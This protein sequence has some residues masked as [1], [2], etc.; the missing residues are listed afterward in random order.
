MTERD[1]RWV[2]VLGL[3]VGLAEVGLRTRRIWRKGRRSLGDEPRTITVQGFGVINVPP[4]QAR[5]LLGV[6]A[7]SASAQEASAQNAQAMTVVLEALKALGIEGKYVQTHTFSLSPEFSHQPD[8]AASPKGYQATNNINVIITDIARVGSILDAAITAAGD[9]IL[10]H[11]VEFVVSNLDALHERARIVALADARHQA[12]VIAQEMGLRLGKAIKIQATHAPRL[13]QPA[14][15][16]A[17]RSQPIEAG[18]MDVATT[19]EVVFE[20][21]VS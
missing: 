2:R 18:E 16:M 17:M 4:D 15:R 1:R 8:G 6:Q 3:A 13:H 5:V 9:H 7:R 14:M 12:L 11:Q 21:L 19:I 20:A 10:I